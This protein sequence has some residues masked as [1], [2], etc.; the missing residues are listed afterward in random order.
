ML[1]SGHEEWVPGGK[2]QDAMTLYLGKSSRNDYSF[3]FGYGPI[4]SKQSLPHVILPTLTIFS[5]NILR[6][7][8]IHYSAVASEPLFTYAYFYCKEEDASSNKHVC[9]DNQNV[10]A[11]TWDNRG[12]FW[13]NHMIVFCPL[14][15]DER[16]MT[17]LFTKVL[18]ANGKPE[19]QN[20]MDYWRPVRARTLFHE[21]YHWET[22]VSVPRCLDKGYTPQ[23]VVDLARDHEDLAVINAE[24]YT[25][26]AMAVY[27][28]KEF[29]LSMPPTP[30]SSAF[31]GEDV[32]EIF[33]DSPPSDWVS[34]VDLESRTFNP[35]GPGIRRLSELGPL[36]NYST[37]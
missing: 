21:T 22:T 27:L 33:L 28:Q 29:G 24:S 34:P 32:T 8:R 17:S 25:Q 20:T 31:V 5:V 12:W 4:E 9:R 7:W 2:W 3:L 13:T 19:M 1:A 23:Q 35:T 37:K 11:Y 16:N 18:Q 10:T 14:F 15:F 30:R 26:A 6:K 36:S